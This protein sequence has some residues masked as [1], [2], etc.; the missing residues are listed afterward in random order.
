LSSIGIGIGVSALIAMLSIGEGAKKAALDKIASLGVRS[1]R[2]ENTGLTHTG[3][4]ES[5]A[6]VTRGMTGEDAESLSVWLGGR[7]HVGAYARI[8]DI[9]VVWN[10][11]AE[12]ATILGVS[13]E[14]FKAESIVPESGR[15]I[16]D[17]DIVFRDNVCVVGA[18]IARNLGSGKGS[19]LRIDGQPVV[20]VGLLPL[21]GRLLTEGTGLSSLDFDSTVIVP[22]SFLPSLGYNK[23]IDRLDGIVITMKVS[24]KEAI[25]GIAEQVRELLGS[26]HHHVDDFT[27]VVPVNLL[28]EV[29]E[30]QKLFSFIMGAIAGLS[31]LVGGIG[32]MNVML[33]NIAEQT[34]EIGLRMAMGASRVRIVSLYLWNAVL[35]TLSGGIW[36]VGSGI[37][38]ALAIQRYGGWDVVISS[39]ALI[40]A[41]FSAIAAGI[42]FG[43]HPAVR[44]ASLSPA[45]ALRDS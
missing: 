7:A 9:T 20:T 22:I 30:N 16:D 13:K 28:E 2:I 35:L 44:A 26:N 45:L 21:R 8:D 42:I 34:R 41:P 39:F 36:G 24:E 19:I 23:D 10:N 25:T 37:L 1:L 29:N 40:I 14:W 4:G 43:V 32:V 11:E 6:N 17:D 18:G 27:L 31:L 15:L 5:L 3:E 12:Q 38:L 33:A